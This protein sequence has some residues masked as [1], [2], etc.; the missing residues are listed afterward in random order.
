ME[1]VKEMTIEQAQKISSPAIRSLVVENI[2]QKERIRNGETS[3]IICGYS[4]YT[5]T[6]TCKCTCVLGG[7]G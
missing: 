4:K 1:L 6:K 7:L 5:H 3:H 2:S